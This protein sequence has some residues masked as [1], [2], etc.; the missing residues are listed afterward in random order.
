MIFQLNFEQFLILDFDKVDTKFIRVKLNRFLVLFCSF[1]NFSRSGNE[2]TSLQR[3][4]HMSQ[5]HR[6]V[7]PL[8]MFIIKLKTRRGLCA[9]P[10][11]VDRRHR[12]Q[13]EHCSCQP[14]E[15]N[16]IACHRHIG[17][18]TQRVTAHKRT[19]TRKL[20][21]KNDCA[22]CPADIR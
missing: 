19:F 16:C 17:T 21:A 3:W 7:E 1:F 22:C 9:K 20:A 12:I 13:C 4:K 5:A 14:I 11:R 2:I 6:M 10:D 8:N 18:C 15:I